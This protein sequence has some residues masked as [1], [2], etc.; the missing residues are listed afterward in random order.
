MLPG[1]VFAFLPSLGFQ[2]MLV[3][4][5]IG[6]LLYGRNLPEAGRTMGRALAHLRRSFQEFK[7]Q[8]D[9]DADLRDVKQSL[10]D[11]ASEF[12]RVADVPRAMADPK[13]ALQ[14]LA[15][16]ALTSA[17]PDEAAGKNGASDHGETG[18]APGSD[19]R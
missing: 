15:R 8:M 4:L 2:E 13:R 17:P 14:D 6:L 11:T 1:R 9:G 7:H 5:V 12:R 18:E 10:R 3:L 16:D 19:G